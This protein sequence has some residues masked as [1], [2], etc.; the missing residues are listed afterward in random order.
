MPGLK[1]LLAPQASELRQHQRV[2]SNLTE[3]DSPLQHSGIPEAP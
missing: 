3:M 2:A 1:A